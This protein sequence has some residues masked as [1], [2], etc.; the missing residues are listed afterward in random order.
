MTTKNDEVNIYLAILTK[1]RSCCKAAQK[2]IT[3]KLYE[4]IWV[5][6]ISFAV[7]PVR[8]RTF[9]QK[10]T[11]WRNEIQLTEFVAVWI[12]EVFIL[13]ATL[14]QEKSVFQRIW[15][16]PNDAIL[17]TYEYRNPIYKFMLSYILI[18]FLI[19]HVHRLSY[20]L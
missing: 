20:I 18:N 12:G 16:I 19:T 2:P 5:S 1:M 13:S 17:F 15:N 7:T 11:V 14:T 6:W 10:H 3:V 8:F 4:V 9:R